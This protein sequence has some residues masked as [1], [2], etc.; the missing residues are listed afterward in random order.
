MAIN[1]PNYDNCQKLNLGCG[2]ISSD[3]CPPG[4]CPDF[5]IR[6]HDVKPSF[7]VQIV[8]CEESVDL[9]DRVLEVNMWALAK[10]KKS[11]VPADTIIS[12]ADAIGFEQV[13]AGDMIIMDR[14]RSPEHILVLG[15]DEDAKTISVARGRQGTTA[16]T[17]KKGSKLRIFRIM[18]SPAHTEMVFNDVEEI[19]GEITKDVLQGSYF[20]YEWQPQDT[21]LPGCFWM[22]FKLIKMKGLTYFLPGGHWTGPVHIDASGNFLTGTIGSDGAVLLSFKPPVTT[23]EEAMLAREHNAVEGLE[24]LYGEWAE[25]SRFHG[26]GR[27]EDYE[28]LHGEESLREALESAIS[29]M[30][31]NEIIHGSPIVPVVQYIIPHG[32]AWTGPTHLWSDGNSYTG[33]VHSDGSLYLNNDGIAAPDS[34]SYNQSGISVTPVLD[35]GQISHTSITEVS[36]T[37]FTQCGIGIDV[38]W[39][40]RFPTERDGFLIRIFDSPTQEL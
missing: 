39:V 29:D 12:F 25:I 37:S 6:R 14:V 30:E 7:R 4:V 17:W 21:C 13:M 15:F 31:G 27:L 3:G 32:I 19:T 34:V 5:T 28:K 9:A 8:D 38:E 40:R 35:L 11:I 16:G 20:V 33:T 2:C 18:N 24:K 1:Y 23:G 22:E 36:M 26:G 10:L